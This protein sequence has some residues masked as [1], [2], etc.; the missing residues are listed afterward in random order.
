[1]RRKDDRLTLK[2]RERGEMM[3]ERQFRRQDGSDGNMSH[4]RRITGHAPR[5][6]GRRKVIVPALF[7]PL[8]LFI[9]CVK[10]RQPIVTLGT[11][12]FVP[13]SQPDSLAETGIGQDPGSGGIS[14]QWYSAKGAAGYKVFR[15]DTVDLSG[16]PSMF[17]VVSILSSATGLNDTST[18]DGTAFQ[19]VRYYYF[20]A[21]YGPDQAVGAP[22]DTVSYE[23]LIRPSLTYPPPNGTIDEGSSYFRWIDNTGGGYTVVRV[24]DVGAAPARYIWVSSRFQVFETNANRSFN[25]DSVATSPL[26]SGHTYQW[27]VDRFNPDGAGRPYEGS[28]SVWSAFAV[29]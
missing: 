2:D 6:L 18:V 22:S 8:V 7:V 21:A 16:K 3:R 11:P 12:H 13:Q 5:T 29:K 1:M 28:R 17:S 4:K 27:R 25:F 23:L 19:G 15:T 14:M 10:Q 20:V 24:K 9:G 26:V